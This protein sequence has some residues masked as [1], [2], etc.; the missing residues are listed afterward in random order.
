MKERQK[1]QKAMELTEGPYYVPAPEETSTKV[2]FDLQGHVIIV[3]CRR[4]P[5]G[6]CILQI[7]GGGELRIIP[8]KREL[9][10]IEC[11]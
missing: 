8:V 5:D 3:C 9:I 4:K 10:Y 11:K 2:Q 7:E 1:Q 6:N